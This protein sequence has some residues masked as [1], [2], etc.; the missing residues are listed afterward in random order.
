[1]CTDF[2]G[3]CALFKGLVSEMR[4]Q[5]W[6]EDMFTKVKIL[7]A[8]WTWR[9]CGHGLVFSVWQEQKSWFP[10]QQ[11]RVSED[12]PYSCCVSACTN[13]KESECLNEDCT[14]TLKDC[15]HT[16]CWQGRHRAWRR[17]SWQKAIL[18]QCANWVHFKEEAQR[19]PL[20]WSTILVTFA[21]GLIF[22]GVG[23]Y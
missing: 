10:Y 11:Q 3:D 15:E 2:G 16:S 4:C 7:P 5:T 6:D 22:L 13:M 9:F 20:L 17:Q 12:K 1:M 14:S 19:S 21:K 23:L 18:Q 8:M